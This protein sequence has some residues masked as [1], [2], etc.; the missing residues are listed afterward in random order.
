MEGYFAVEIERV[1]SY[2][3]GYIELLWRLPT[4]VKGCNSVMWK[5]MISNV[6]SAE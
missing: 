4:S 3:D 2:I 1:F 6:K 5:D